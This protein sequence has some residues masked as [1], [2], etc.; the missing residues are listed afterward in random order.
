MMQIQ[1]MSRLALP[2]MILATIATITLAGELFCDVFQDGDPST[3]DVQV[4][5][6]AP[7][8]A[9]DSRTTSRSQRYTFTKFF[10]QLPGSVQEEYKNL[11][12]PGVKGTSQTKHPLNMESCKVRLDSL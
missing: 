1:T 6:E 4:V 7:D 10:D 8:G 3:D 9:A 2:C 11:S 5:D 12:K